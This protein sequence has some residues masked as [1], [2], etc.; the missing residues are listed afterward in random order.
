MDLASDD[1][2]THAGF[3]GDQDAEVGGRDAVHDGV[4]LLHLGMVGVNP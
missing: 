1:L 3:P 4:D 2:F